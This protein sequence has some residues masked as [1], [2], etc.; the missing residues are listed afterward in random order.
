M[1]E[2]LLRV[3]GSI[4]AGLIFGVALAILWVVFWTVAVPGTL[5]GQEWDGHDALT[6]PIFCFGWLIGTGTGVYASFR[7]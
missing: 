2:L 5:P 1:H 4:L 6:V 3:I 7:S